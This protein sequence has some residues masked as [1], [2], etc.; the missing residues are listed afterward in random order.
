MK[1]HADTSL[2]LL[3]LFLEWLREF[4]FPVKGKSLHSFYALRLPGAGLTE[5]YPD[6]CA[7]FPA[8]ILL[9]HTLQKAK[10]FPLSLLMTNLPTFVMLSI[11]L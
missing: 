4:R 8:T 6:P 10:S 9:L 3:V 5:T 1:I 2:L 7:L 11:F